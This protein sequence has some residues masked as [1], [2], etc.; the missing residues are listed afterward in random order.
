MTWLKELKG[1]RKFRNY[2]KCEIKIRETNVYRENVK[3][4]KQ[5]FAY[6][7]FWQ[8]V[9]KTANFTLTLTKD[10]DRNAILRVK[11]GHLTLS[12]RNISVTSVFSSL[13]IGL[14]VT[15]GEA[16]NDYEKLLLPFV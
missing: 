4:G 12:E 10:S 16:Y 5:E 13:N 15:R 3:D 2:H 8:Q 1:H 6:E 7:K 11:D 9:A 14:M